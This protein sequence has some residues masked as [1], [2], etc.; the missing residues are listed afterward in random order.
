MVVHKGDAP[1]L[2]RIEPFRIVA[3]LELLASVIGLMIL[4][5]DASFSSTSVGSI[6]F[7]AGTDNQ[8]NSKL[9]EKH[10]TT[11]FPLCLV[12]LELST[13]LQKRDLALNL[14]WLERDANQPADDLT[15]EKFEAF[16]PELRVQMEW[17][18]FPFEKLHELLALAKD[19]KEEL[20]QAKLNRPKE[21]EVAR[22]PKRAKLRDRDP[23]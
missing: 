11:K 14:T 1:W 12:L 17:E 10:M 21:V 22:G 7:S 5:P 3:S 2:F 13:Q 19:F 18:E 9:V 23:W 16:S 20:S 15:N 8:C 6:G 4:V